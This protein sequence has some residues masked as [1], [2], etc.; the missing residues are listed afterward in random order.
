MAA[1]VP[2]QGKGRDRQGQGGAH[3]FL[4]QFRHIPLIVIALARIAA[5]K[6]GEAVRIL[7]GHGL[8]QMQ[9]HA[10]RGHLFFGGAVRQHPVGRIPGDT[11]HAEHQAPDE[12]DAEQAFQ[13]PFY[14]ELEHGVPSF[15]QKWQATMCPPP[16]SRSGGTS[17][18]QTV[19]A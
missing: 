5:Q 14:R 8:V 12:P 7:F 10:Q 1:T 18:P 9:R 13:Q 16:I 3:A 2:N 4:V 19:W 17:A 15:P 11:H 6:I